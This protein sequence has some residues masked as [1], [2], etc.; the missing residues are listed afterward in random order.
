MRFQ[1]FLR[2]GEEDADGELEYGS[3]YV[4]YDDNRFA[5]EEGI[6]LWVP[7]LFRWQ[8]SACA[9]EIKRSLKG[10]TVI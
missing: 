2:G 9:Q 1:F 8:M 3:D 10:R 6:P 7:F 5:I 4:E